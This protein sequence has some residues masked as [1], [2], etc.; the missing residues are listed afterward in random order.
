MLPNG[1]KAG[2]GDYFF[3]LPKALFECTGYLKL[4]KTQRALLI[5]LCSQFNGKN[6]GNLTLAPSIME[7]LGWDEKTVKRNKQALLDSKL[8]R[9]SGHKQLNN[10]RYMYL[11]AIA[12]LEIDDCS[13]YID[14]CSITLPKQS[15]K[16]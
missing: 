13:D 1:R 15:L 8:I 7:A 11:Y 14:R 3:R 2:T 10:K 5:D 12:W 4:N 6:N 9:I 16:F